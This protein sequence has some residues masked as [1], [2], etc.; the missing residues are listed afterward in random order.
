MPEKRLFKHT[1]LTSIGWFSLKRL[2]I[3]VILTTSNLI[4]VRFLFPDDF[5]TFAIIQLFITS[6]WVLA[7][8]S[9]GRALIQMEGE[10]EGRLLQ[11]VWFVQFGLGIIIVAVLWFAAP[12]VIEF[13]GGNLGENGI[14]IL[15][16]TALSQ[17]FINMG[18]VSASLLERRLQF[19]QIA[20]TEFLSLLIMQIITVILASKGAGVISFVWGQIGG[21]FFQFILYTLFSP[22]KF[23]FSFQLSPLKKLIAFGLP[24]QLSTFFQLTSISIIPLFVGRFSGPSGINGAVAVGYITWAAGVA[25]LPVA[26]AGIVEQLIFAFIS[27][28]RKKRRFTSSVFQRIMRGV[29]FV[30]FFPAVTLFVLASNVTTVVYTSNWLPAVPLLRLSIIQVLIITFC[31][32]ASSSLMAYGD[33]RYLRNLQVL[34]TF[35]QFLFTIPL[36]VLIGFWTVPLV[37]IIV[38]IINLV[39]FS[40]LKLEIQFSFFPL[41]KYA[42]LASVTTGAVIYMVNSQLPV[43]NIF[44]LI[45]LCF[46]GLFTYIAALFVLGKKIFIGDLKLYV[47]MI[48]DSFAKTLPNGTKY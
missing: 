48:K 41:F 47:Q 5:G 45:L 46:L 19:F 22:W 20:A 10:P 44:T 15:R 35:I 28:I 9:L 17:I 23:G 33:T 25:S 8:I 2:L 36:V 4:L 30:T 38:G 14:F 34:L 40:R 32:L 16:Y 13:Y 26:F 37:G 6:V 42:F 39:V 43:S 29:S 18:L 1:V 31:R 24:L 12:V 27:R 3:Q 21:R 7:D 11:T